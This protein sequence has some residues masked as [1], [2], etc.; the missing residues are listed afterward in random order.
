MIDSLPDPSIPPIVPDTDPLLLYIDGSYDVTDAKGGWAFV[1]VRH[2]K[3]VISC[4]GPSDGKS[5]NTLE[6]LA[7]IKAVEWAIQQAESTD[8]TLWSDSAY[9]VEGCNTWRPIWRNNG[10]KRYSPNP[11]KRNRSI[12]DADLWRQMDRLL[13]DRPDITVAWCKGHQGNTGNEL[14]DRLAGEARSA[15]KRGS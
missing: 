9:V 13:L 15:P 6:L 10:W 14:A 5:N 11:K 1:A 4:S 8:I 3:P 2:G 7:A 12:P